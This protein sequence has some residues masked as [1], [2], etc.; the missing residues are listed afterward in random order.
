MNEISE[1]MLILRKSKNL[2]Q[3]DISELLNVS[4]QVY[5]RY[6][7]GYR[8]TKTRIHKKNGRLL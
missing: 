5:N 8:K 6:E 1:K 4:I 7:L 3:R 2:L